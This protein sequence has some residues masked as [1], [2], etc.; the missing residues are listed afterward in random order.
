MTPGRRTCTWGLR[1]S[2]ILEHFGATLILTPFPTGMLGR[3]LVEEATAVVVMAVVVVMPR[4]PLRQLHQM[5]LAVPV[6]RILNPAHLA[7][8]AN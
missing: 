5:L 4:Q 8:I 7:T 1:C 2:S 3:V 6:F